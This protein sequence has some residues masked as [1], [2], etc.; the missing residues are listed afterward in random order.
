MANPTTSNRFSDQVAL[1]T[2][3]AAGIGAATVRRFVAEGASVLIA[4]LDTER[5]PALANEL[6]DSVAFLKTDVSHEEDVAA[7]VMEA[8]DRFGRLDILFNNAGFGGAMGPIATT[9]VEDYDLTFDVLLKSVFLGTKHG[10]PAMTKT[11]G[12]A[13]VNT[14]SVAGLKPGYSPHLY[15]VAK[16]AVISFTKT[17]ALELATQQIRCNAVCP[18]FVATNL[19]AGHPNADAAKVDQLRQGAANAQPLGRIGEPEDIADMVTFLA[20]SESSWI[21]GQHFVVDGGILAGPNWEDFP[22]AFTESHPIK[23][24][25]PPD[26]G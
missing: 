4:D 26:R 24:H 20:S 10:S 5:G 2:G 15:S 18:G 25:R 17:V 12:G 16:A 7:M 13:I 11:G 9:S 23:H 1:V 3:G 19:A 8:T 21:T 22:K 14:A 6:G